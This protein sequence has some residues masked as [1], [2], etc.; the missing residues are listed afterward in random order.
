MTGDI[1]NNIQLIAD[2]A[3]LLLTALTALIVFYYTKETYLLRKE[4][5]KQTLNL[6]TPY[7]ALRYS[8]DYSLLLVNLGKGIAKDVTF[9]PT[10]QSENQIMLSVPIIGAGEEK[11]FRVQSESG[12]GTYS[13]QYCKTPDN[14]SLVYFDT[15]GNKYKAEF[16]KLKQ[17]GNEF[18]ELYQKMLVT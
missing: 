13:A 12:E 16:I 6:F 15:L 11:L 1:S 9:D 3:L 5:Q 8:E 7:L 14:I 10:T 17:Y 2:N 18:T 4:T